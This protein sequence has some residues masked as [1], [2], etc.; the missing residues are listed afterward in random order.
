MTIQ[1]G[2][3]APDFSLRDT[4]KNVVTLG[5]QR[6]KNVVLLFFPLAFTSVCTKELCM[7]RD[8]LTMYNDLNATIFGISVDSLF[9]LKRFKEDQQL[10]FSLLSDFN[11]TT[12]AALARWLVASSI[13]GCRRSTCRPMPSRTSPAWRARRR[14]G[15]SDT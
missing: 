12:S 13:S 1:I 15:L 4:D 3:T 2:Q 5:E 8:N 9:S 6:G 11:K 14:T 10:N 7:T